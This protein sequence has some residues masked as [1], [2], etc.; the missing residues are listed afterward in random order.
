MKILITGGS[1]L[2]GKALTRSLLADGHSV[3]VLTRRDPAP[4]SAMQGLTLVHWDGRTTSGWGH[5]VSGMEA[6]INLAGEPLAR[7]PW[8]KSQKKRF[9]DS[10]VHAGEAV[11]E[12][13]RL[14]SPR[15]KVLIQASGINHYGLRGAPADESTPPGNDFLARLSVAWEDA[16]KEV[17]S[18]GVRRCVIRTAVVLARG[19]GLFPLMALPV[20]IFLGGPLGSGQQT[21]PWIHLEDEI[22]A[23]RFLLENEKASGPYN[24]IAPEA[25]T[26]AGFNRL[27]AKALR[28]PYWFPTPAFLLKI[29]LGEMSVLV[30]EGR[31]ASPKRLLEAGYQFRLGKLEEALLQSV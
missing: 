12:A 21:V 6:V 17:E 29:V 3:W 7:W 22:G 8:T 31:A 5:L 11:T 24:L 10:R 25:V 15:P 23:I 30:L 20:R 2:I 9:W 26:S 18:L 1:G 27:L 28:R 19:G 14:A 13:I 4:A 16:T